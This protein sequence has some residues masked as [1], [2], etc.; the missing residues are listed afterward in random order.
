MVGETQYTLACSALTLPFKSEVSTPMMH[1]RRPFTRSRSLCALA[2][3]A[4]SLSMA[5]STPD[6]SSGRDLSDAWMHADQDASADMQR[7]QN[8]LAL[9]DAAP[10]GDQDRDAEPEQIDL[11]PEELTIPPRPWD[12]TERGPFNVGFMTGSYT[13]KVEPSGEDRTIEVVFWYPTRAARGTSAR[14]IKNL[15]LIGDALDRA[16][17]A[18][19]EASYPM[20]VFSH[21]NGSIAEQSYTMTE[22]FASHGWIV[23]APYHTLN[24]LFDNPSVINYLSSV[25]RPQDISALLDWSETLP[26]DHPLSGRINFEQMAISGHS[27]G[28]FT[29]MALAGAQFDVDAIERQCEGE[30][31]QIG[32][33]LCELF[34]EERRELFERGFY[35]PRFKAAIPQTPGIGPVFEDGVQQLKMPLLMMTAGRDQSLRAELNGDYMWDRLI[36]GPHARFDLPNGGHFTYSNMCSLLGTLEIASEDGCDETFIDVDAALMMIV[37]YAM[38]WAEYHVLGDERHEALIRGEERPYP[39]EDLV[40]EILPRA[41]SP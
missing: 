38:A 13:F 28:A 1:R 26:A 29:T 19:T 5:C 15:L 37:H 36:E 17:V 4:L 20:L 33:S 2:L 9:E 39:E 23:A 6:E 22:H 27:F 14:Y 21:G 34:T 7:D 35:E 31:P 30:T 24:T 16:E 40:Y 32:R 8:A 41:E 25:D 3:A 18:D 11:G 12:V 10:G